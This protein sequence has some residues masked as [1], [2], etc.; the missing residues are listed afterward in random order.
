M[1]E[2]VLAKG[3]LSQWMETSSESVKE[4]TSIVSENFYKEISCE[5]S[6]RSR[7]QIPHLKRNI[8]NKMYYA[9]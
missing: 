8:S 3:K 6:G 7:K 2:I 1:E 9:G 4:C 5:R